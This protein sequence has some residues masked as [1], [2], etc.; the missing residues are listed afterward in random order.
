MPVREKIQELSNSQCFGTCTFLRASEL[1]PLTNQPSWTNQILSVSSY[2]L[3]GGLRAGY[4]PRRLP[5]F[6]PILLNVFIFK[7]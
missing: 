5:V 2:L 7:L 4:L 6:K 3:D 1:S